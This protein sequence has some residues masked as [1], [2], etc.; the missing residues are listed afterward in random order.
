MGQGGRLL[1]LAGPVPR[2][3]LTLKR[4]ASRRSRPEAFRVCAPTARQNDIP[5][6]GLDAGNAGVLTQGHR[7][8][9]ARAQAD[10]T[11]DAGPGV[12]DG[13]PALAI[14]ARLEVER[15]VREFVRRSRLRK[16]EATE[17]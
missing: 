17:R 11:T 2:E 13:H 15:Q 1:P 7:A 9:R 16:P 14:G 4:K 12:D 8:E 5:A 3:V 6:G 10:A